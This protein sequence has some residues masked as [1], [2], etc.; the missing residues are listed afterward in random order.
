MSTSLLY[1]GFGIIGYKYIRTQYTNGT[2]VITIKKDFKD[3]TCPDCGHHKLIRRGTIVRSFRGLTPGEK[4]IYVCA[5]IQR[6]ECRQCGCV[7]QERT[8]FADEK[9]SYIKAFA[10]YVIELSKHMTIKDVANHLNIS[11]DVVKEIQKEHLQ[12]K[13]AK[14]E[15]CDLEEIAIDEISVG[16]HHKYLTV[17]L[18]LKNGA[19][20]L[21]P[22]W[23]RLK[24]SG[25]KIKAAAID[26]SPAFIE[27]VMNNLPQ[28]QIVFDHFHIIKLYND[29]LSE[30]RRD[31]QREIKEVL[32]R[33]VLKGT[34]WLL[35][36]NPE[37]LDDA[38]NERKRLK[39][40][41]KSIN[42]WLRLIT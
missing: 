3:L 27:A 33:D 15:L 21:I 7:K 38:K 5:I 24:R 40:P 29:K 13:F 34:R 42:L 36:K 9:K 41:C 1:H 2:I 11:W 23:K 25:A 16:M 12:K 20:S 39:K 35:L 26:M 6:V 14:P 4:R 10:R 32:H 8:H 30:L 18:D 28:A 19:D 17:V 37:N 31:L 22:F